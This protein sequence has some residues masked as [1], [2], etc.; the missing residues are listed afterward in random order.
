M[1]HEIDTKQYN[2]AKHLREIKNMAQQEREEN[3]ILEMEVTRLGR[4]DKKIK[5]RKELLS[6]LLDN[7]MMHKTPPLAKITSGY[8]TKL[9]SK[10][11]AIG[12]D[13]IPVNFINR[14][15]SYYPSKQAVPYRG[16]SDFL[17]LNDRSISF[18]EED[19]IGVET[20]R[21]RKLQNDR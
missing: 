13:T 20:S 8:S 6:S 1:K 12:Y 18:D 10:V 16:N 21:L 15:S 5:D 2:M 11:D 9:Q 19:H 17:D 14:P 7:G 3:V 4:K